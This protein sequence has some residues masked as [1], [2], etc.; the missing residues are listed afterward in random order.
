MKHPAPETWVA[1]VYDELAV[2]AR[3]DVEAH[4]HVC[5]ACREHVGRLRSTMAVLDQDKA[6]LVGPRRRSASAAVI[7]VL[8]WA[9]AASVVLCAGFIAGRATGPSRADVQREIATVRQDLQAQFREELK[10]AAAVSVAAAADENRRLLTEFAR[11]L[12][13]GR[14]ADRKDLLAALDA[15]DQRRALDTEALRSG[16]LTL[17][18]RTGTGFQ[19]TES[20][21]NLLASYLPAEPAAA[22]PVPDSSKPA[23]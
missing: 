2:P 7:P 21:L 14:T 23:P 6:S 10:S 16:L 22:I 20:Q 9:L 18:R 17:A 19:Q 11:D 4:L 13:A 8:R 5:P 12:Q 3:A 15:L 1:Y